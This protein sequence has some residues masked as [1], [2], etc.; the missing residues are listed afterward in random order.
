M[1]L[2]KKLNKKLEEI[3]KTRHQTGFRN[4]KIRSIFNEILQKG[5]RHPTPSQNQKSHKRSIISFLKRDYP[6]GVAHLLEHSF[7]LNENHEEKSINTNWN[8]Y[9]AAQN[10]VFQFESSDE[11]FLAAFTEKWKMITEFGKG[12]LSALYSAIL[13]EVSA[14]NNE[15]EMDISNTAWKYFLTMKKFLPKEHP[16][17]RFSI[18]SNETLNFSSVG[19]EVLRFFKEEYSLDK[20]K[21]V[22]VC[23][24]EQ[25]AEYFS[26]L[27][28]IMTNRKSIAGTNPP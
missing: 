15:Y 5:N 25:S 17:A 9:T 20:M 13:G 18:G 7:F 28:T 16:H 23:N 19:P 12:D 22:T 8:A 3:L 10:T 6:Q 21:I 14:V 27:S 26:M 24:Q 4:G 1:K 11:D 2:G